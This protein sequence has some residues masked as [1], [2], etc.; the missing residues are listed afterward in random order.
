VY[1]FKWD[2]K[3]LILTIHPGKT[4]LGYFRIRNLGYKVLS[5]IVMG[6]FVF[7]AFRL[8]QSIYITRRSFQDC[9]FNVFIFLLVA[10][11]NLVQTANLT[12][13]ERLAKFFTEF[14]QNELRLTSKGQLRNLI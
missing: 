7:A 1:P 14:L 6:N 3:A 13:G 10:L 2:R 4:Y 11:G 9:M 5:G 12:R 8:W